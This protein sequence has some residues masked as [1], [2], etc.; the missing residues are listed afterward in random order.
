LARSLTRRTFLG[1]TAGLLAARPSFSAQASVASPSVFSVPLRREPPYE[2]LRALIPPQADIFQCEIRAAEISTALNGLSSGRMLPLAASFEGQS[3]QPVRWEELA[4]DASVA[5]FDGEDA[6]FADGLAAWLTTRSQLRFYPLEQDLVRFEAQS[7]AGYH[8]GHWHF[9]WREGGLHSFRPVDEVRTSPRRAFR[10]AQIVD[11]NDDAARQLGTGIPEWR[12]QIDVTAG[13][14]IYGQNGIAVG[15]IDND[16]FDEI[17][18]CQPGG[19]PNRLLKRGSDGVYRDISRD[20]GVDLLDS[21]SCALFVDFRNS[22][23]QD[24]VVLTGSQPLFFE[25]NG[26]GSFKYL[27][28]T[29][30]FAT[31]PQ[32]AFTG[33][34]AADYDGDGFV[35]LYLCTY[36]YFRSEDQYS[37]PAP[38]H[39]A[40]NGPP[41]YLFRNRLVADQ[42]FEDVTVA[43]GLNENNDRYSFAPAWCDFDFDGRPE[44]YVAN[45]FGRNNLYKFDG[46]RFRDIAADAGVEDIGPG[47]S[48]AWFDAHGS[49]RPDL[50][51][52]NMWS[53][54]GR[55]VIHDPAFTLVT[56]Q[57]LGEEFRRHAKGN[58]LYRNQGDG[59]FEE[60]GQAEMGRWAWTG[61]AFDFD[62]DGTPEIVVAAGMVSEPSDGAS[63]PMDSDLM[64]FFWRQ[65][66]A[67]SSSDGSPAPKYEDGWNAINQF[68]REGYS[69]NGH[70]PNVF[71]KRR[72]GRW[73]DYS[74]DLGFESL[75]TRSFA[76]TDLTGD[77][78]LDLIL[79]NRL[80]PQIQPLLNSASDGNV[81][82]V[83]LEGSRSNRDA[84]GAWVVVE[85]SNGVTSQLLSAGSGYLCQHTK[86]VHL[87]LGAADV[88]DSVTVHWP[89]GDAEEFEGIATGRRYRIVEGQ[90]I[91]EQAALGTAQPMNAVVVAAEPRLGDVWLIEPVPLPERSPGPRLLVITREELEESTDRAAWYTLF[92]RYLL[93]HRSPLKLPLALLIDEDSRAHK[94][95]RKIPS[96]ETVRDDLTLM[97][98]SDRTQL[99]LPFPGWYAGGIPSR[100]FYRHGAAFF[101][102]GYPDQA[103]PYLDTVLA[104]TPDNFKAQLVVGQI[105]LDAERRDAARPHI[106]TCIRLQP[107]SAEAWNNY[108]G[109]AML[110]Q[111]YELAFE[112]FAKAIALAPNSGYLH[113]NAAQAADRAGQAAEAERLLRRALEID[114]DEAGP[115]SQLGLLLAKQERFDEAKRL[116]ERAIELQRD[117]VGAINNLAVLYLRLNQPTQAIAALR[118][119]IR[120]APSSEETYMNLARVY[121]QR[122][123][124][125]NARRVLEQSLEA[126][127]DS[128]ITRRA[129]EELSR[130]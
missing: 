35:D 106:E 86:H 75:D 125:D 101:Q 37:Y 113:A 24:L 25:N 57:G 67:N 46:V 98:D 97:G 81:I 94:L 121:I 88:A 15:D 64:S 83:E 13:I 10:A 69:W 90:G 66:V 20:V 1:A 23:L 47:M 17:Y 34:S 50:Y 39:D 100:N 29:F 65:A 42:Q 104:R 99:A 44:L 128:T 85:S 115:S 112:R 105:H 122:S 70:E 71:Y 102:A 114:P 130:L 11:P 96:D 19:L 126:L 56:D 40:R 4:D 31:P 91:V 43:V 12:R 108:G 26:K 30:Q 80:A 124:P 110:E 58:T 36:V 116:F 53:P 18:V 8:V 33:M 79:K 77:G 60:T 27:P 52:T 123:D 120:V 89:S 45:D 109:L 59:S 22:G 54:A 78:R 2:K 87:G 9:G 14:D 82:V 32:G 84:I 21:T 127:P 74:S 38:Y 51:V 68:I 41:N 63:D 119:G 73:L 5:H 92:Q 49:G 7:E 28:D 76:A 111:N 3:P 48:A 103:L 118:Y 117:H 72:E 93:D 61:D 55:R 95:Y 62:A 129:L 6:Q 107:D 16:G